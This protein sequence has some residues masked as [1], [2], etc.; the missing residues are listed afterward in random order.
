[1]RVATT[2]LSL[3]LLACGEAREPAPTATSAD[4]S[5]W[6]PPPRPAA[7][8]I[9]SNRVDVVRLDGQW[10]EVRGT[11]TRASN[12]APVPIPRDG[13]WTAAQD[14]WTVIRLDDGTTLRVAIGAPPEGWAA[15][16][17]RHVAVVALVWNGSPREGPGAGGSG[18]PSISSWEA[19]RELAR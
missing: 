17:G 19:P 10:A 15:L 8:E 3:C 1:M 5:A 18:Q 6:A 11:V 9:V 4:A 13:R 12:P 16:E 2:A 7:P 14:E